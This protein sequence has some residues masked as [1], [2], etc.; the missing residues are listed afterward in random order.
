MRTFMV[1]RVT[2]ASMTGRLRPGEGSVS[3]LSMGLTHRRKP[4]RRAYL[5]QGLC[6]SQRWPQ[7][8][9]CR[10]GCSLVQDALDALVDVREYDVPYHMRF[11]IDTDVR[12]GHWFTV[13][14][15]ARPPA[16]QM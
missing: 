2:P 12:C 1:S 3:C 10:Q 8:L 16:M 6:D 15:K 4:P 7:S 13:T 9:H 5:S 11:Q 14:A